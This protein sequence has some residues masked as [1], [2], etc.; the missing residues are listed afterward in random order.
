MS[1]LYRSFLLTLLLGTPVASLAQAPAP[2]LS[3][4]SNDPTDTVLAEAP[5]WTQDNSRPALFTFGD[6]CG[7]CGRC[8]KC[9]HPGPVVTVYGFGQADWI[10]DFNR[11]DPL[12]EGTLRPSRIPTQD[13]Q[14]GSDGN[15]TVSARQSRLGVDG[16]IPTSCGPITTKFEFDMYGVGVDEGQTT[17][18]LRHAYGEWG[19][20]LGGQTHSLFMD[21]D[22]FPNT[23]DYWGP[24]GMVFLRT[25][26]IRWQ[27]IRGTHNLAISVEAPDTGIDVGEADRILGQFPDVN[28]APV[29]RF[30]DMS[31]KVTQAIPEIEPLHNDL[32]GESLELLAE[33]LVEEELPEEAGNESRAS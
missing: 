3:Q 20:W 7:G 27:P 24:A 28:V 18:R 12:W 15:A 11:V 30:A 19:N 5:R 6:S 4:T 13:G 26:Q 10:Q 23:I 32:Q 2:S 8:Q 16:S 9:T 21:I 29:E 22:V 1:C 31:S 14:F 33:P 25:P 17:F